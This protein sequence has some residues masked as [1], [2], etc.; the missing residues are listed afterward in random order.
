MENIYND[1]RYAARSLLRNPAY[2]LAAILALALGMGANTAIFSLLNAVVLRPLPY[3]EAER[4]SMVWV[5]EPGKQ[6]TNSLPPRIFFGWRQQSQSFQQLACYFEHLKLNLLRPDAYPEQLTAA[7]VSGNFF[8]TLGVSAALGST[9]GEDHSSS[10]QKVAV[11]SYATWQRLAGG[12]AA[13]V[14]Q[15]MMLNNEPYVVLGVMAP[16]FTFP[17]Q[18]DLWVA[19]E[20]DIPLYST[21]IPAQRMYNAGYVRVVGRLKPE[22]SLEAAREEMKAVTTRLYEQWGRD[23]RLPNLVPLHE[24]VVG[25]SA[26]ALQILMATVGLILLIACANV[27]NLSYARAAGRE[28]EIAARVAL[29]AGRRQLLRNLLAESLM[30]ALVSG[31]VGLL[32]GKLVL[33]YLLSLDTGAIPRLQEVGLDAEVLL[34]A[35]GLSLLLGIVLALLPVVK[36]GRIDPIHALKEGG[37]GGQSARSYAQSFL[38][39]AQV[40]ATVVLLV[41]TGLLLKSFVALQAVDPG[42]DSTNLLTFKV[43]L[44]GEKYAGIPQRFT[45]YQSLRERLQRIPGVESAALAY[46]LPFPEQ[47]IGGP[48]YTE[49][50]VKNA[51]VAEE[52][53]VGFEAVSPG[54]FRTM[55]IPILSG[56]DFTDSDNVNSPPVGIVSQTMARRYW[57]DQDPVGSRI[58]RDPKADPILW[59]TV[60]G[61]AGDVIHDSLDQGP[62]AELYFP[63]T[64][65]P[66]GFFDVALRTSQPP[67]SLVPTVRNTVAELD[68]ELPIVNLGTMQQRVS[69]SYSQ[70]QLTLDL[71]M[72]FGLV[73]VLLAVVGIYGMAAYVS[74]KRRPEIGLRMA[75][76]AQPQSILKQVLGQG[77]RLALLGIVLGIAAALALTRLLQ[78]Q[79]YGV[80]AAD[81][82]TYVAVALAAIALCLAANFVPAYRASRIDPLSTLR[83]E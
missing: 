45:F 73:A 18:V 55:Q 29:G 3:P 74:R 47:M 6:Q 14:G 25:Q 49:T 81:P 61:V 69:Q 43:S 78:S 22:M 1:I 54:Y 30:L 48:I 60:I 63:Y 82:W 11:L 56:R 41:A 21:N 46:Y 59:V 27:V 31:L 57:P 9:F 35:L 34:F 26:V 15:T 17:A 67:L 51:E 62:R 76:G 28:R 13:V 38:V 79:L 72:A 33:S 32:L 52:N 80:G 42:F 7:S 23:V 40:A 66:V 12:D 53:G 50:Q 36:A 8:S 20:G 83:Y 19:A 77:L 39:V 44:E 24:Q 71:V 64:Q 37:R 70:S 58:T 75:L 10:R 5:T 2:S 68:P 65:G 4:L 16:E